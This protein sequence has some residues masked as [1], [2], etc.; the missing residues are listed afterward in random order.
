V[1]RTNAA[2]QVIGVTTVRQFSIISGTTVQNPYAEIDT[3]S[4]GGTDSY[5]SLQ[6]T[7][8]RRLA[9]GLTLNSQ[10]SLARSFGITSGSNESRTAAQPT[11]ASP[12]TGSND[13]NNYAA[14]LGYNSF[15]IRHTFN[16]SAVYDLPFGAG[17]PH[18]LSGIA[19]ALFGNWQI[20]GIAN[21]RS[22]IP[23]DV[24]VT[25]PDVVVQCVAASCTINNSATTTTSVAKG[26]TTQLPSVSATQPLPAGFAAVVNAP[27]GG[28]SR[29]TRRPDVIPGVD[30]YLNSDRNFLNPA[31]FTVPVAGT[32]GNL[33]RNAFKGPNF[34][35]FDMI[36]AK[37]FPIKERTSLEFRSEFFNIFNHANFGNPASTLNVGLPTMT[38]NAAT[39]AWVLGSG[40]QPGQ[41]YTQSAAGAAF[42]LLRQ[43]VERTVGLGTNRQVQF[44]LRMNF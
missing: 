42:G 19:N 17:R 27:G 35:Q 23:I 21:L 25:R 38:F 7:L 36:L 40:T 1:N 31:A 14:D 33:A 6:F 37:R 10:Y 30:P 24:T 39:N 43:T 34:Q 29:Q 5:R 2:G 15:D 13:T 16:W 22:G 41:A 9:S 18:S 20:G 26:F 11:G 12:K 8:T 44:A 4:S 3:K 28:S 32:Y